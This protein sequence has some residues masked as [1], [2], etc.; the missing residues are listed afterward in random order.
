MKKLILLLIIAAVVVIIFLF[1]ARN[2]ERAK[3]SEKDLLKIHIYG[4]RTR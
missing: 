4:K 3:V 2:K 1:G